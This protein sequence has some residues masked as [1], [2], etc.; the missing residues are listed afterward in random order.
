[1]K[2]LVLGLGNPLVSDDSVGLRV[3][4]ELR[5]RLA[6]RPDVEVDEDY[7]GGLRLMERMIGYDR[8]I[9]VDAI[10]SG[11]PP[12]T[13]H[14]LTPG[15]IPTR[16]SL[17]AHDVSLPTALE[18]GRRAEVRLPADGQIDLVGIEVDDILTFS[19]SCTP[20]VQAAVTPAVQYV[21]E[22]LGLPSCT[23]CPSS[24]P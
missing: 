14:H 9:I 5:A 1:M 6:G 16:R 8:A 11:A 10:R 3:A 23:S 18:L 7:C 4:A 19:E 17:S 24:R 2:T 12:G 21:I 22:I 13:I 15:D 20:A